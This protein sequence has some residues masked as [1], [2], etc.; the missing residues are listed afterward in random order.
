MGMRVLVVGSGAR[1]HAL[2][3]SS[4]KARESAALLCAP[5]NAGTATVAEP[6]RAVNDLDG[7]VAAAAA[8]RIDLVVIG[9]DDPLAA[10]LADRLRGAG[11]AAF[12]PSAAAARIESSKSWA[13]AIMA[14]AGVPTARATIVTDADRRRSPPSPTSHTRS[15]SRRMASPPAKA[16]SSPS[17]RDDAA[18]RPHRLPRRERPRRRRPHRPD[19]G[20]SASAARL[21]VF[22]LT[23]GET[24]RHLATRLRLQA[25]RRRRPR[26]QHRRHGRLCPPPRPSTPPCLIRIRHIHPRTNDPRRW[27]PTAHRF[28]GVLYAGLMLTARRPQGDRVQRPLRRPGDPGRPPPP[29]RRPPRPPRR[30]RRWHPRRCPT[31]FHHQTAPPSASSSPPAATPALT[32]PGSPSP[33]SPIFPADVLVFHA[34]TRRDDAGRLVTAGGRVLTVVGPAHDLATARARAYAGVAA[35]D[36][37]GTHHR[38]DIAL[39]EV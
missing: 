28:S 17:N 16:S 21:S 7:I 5:G 33:A 32:R 31:T 4:R 6:S 11:S 22:A 12:G 38:T 29:R 2:A 37:Q 10:G 3:G 30:R 39:R 26:S 34:G 15:S 27:P 20:V 14:A 1:E 35:I 8:Q 18:R 9:P 13:K 19:R 25:R 36:F 23:D 24:V